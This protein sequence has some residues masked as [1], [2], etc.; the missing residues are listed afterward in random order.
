MWAPLWWFLRRPMRYDIRVIVGGYRRGVISL[1]FS[2]VW[3]DARLWYDTCVMPKVN[4]FKGARKWYD[5][6]VMLL[7]GVWGRRAAN[8][9]I[10]HT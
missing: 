10:T 1:G 5:I 2:G 4:D 3:P 9:A 6:C 7:L 8:R